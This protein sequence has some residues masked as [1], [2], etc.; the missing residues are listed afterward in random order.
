MDS[1]EMQ[2]LIEIGVSL[3]ELAVRGTVSKINNKIKASKNEKKY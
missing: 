3:T 2:S 1:S